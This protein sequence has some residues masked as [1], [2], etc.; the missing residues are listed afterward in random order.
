MMCDDII[1]NVA[2]VESVGKIFI[3]SFSQLSDYYENVLKDGITYYDVSTSAASE[4]W[5]CDFGLFKKL[6]VDSIL[7]GKNVVSNNIQDDD[8]CGDIFVLN[9]YANVSNVEKDDV[10]VGHVDVKYVVRK[11]INAKKVVVALSH[12][13]VLNIDLSWC[14]IRIQAID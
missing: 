5:P 14:C 4:N 13:I 7:V 12:K 2:L 11:R 1:G 6:I 3:A 8:V 9:D 10:T